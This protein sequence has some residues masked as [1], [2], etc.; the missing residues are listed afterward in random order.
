MVLSSRECGLPKL[1][2]L[3]GRG[4]GEGY[5]GYTSVETALG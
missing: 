5:H 2:V 1:H 4:R 3:V